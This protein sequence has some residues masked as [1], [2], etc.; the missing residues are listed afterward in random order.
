[1]LY[2]CYSKP[3]EYIL[4]TDHLG[5]SLKG[6]KSLRQLQYVELKELSLGMSGG[7]QE[8]AAGVK[9][10]YSKPMLLE[11]LIARMPPK[12]SEKTAVE[13]EKENEFPFL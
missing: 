11:L 3:F 2:I 8:A 10:D 6:P 5:V 13:Q 4:A 12:D 1:M 7:Q 9:S